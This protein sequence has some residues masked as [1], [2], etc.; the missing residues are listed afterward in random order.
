MGPPVSIG[1]NIP[2]GPSVIIEDIHNMGPWSAGPYNTEF[3]TEGA[4]AIAPVLHLSAPQ[5]SW[6][7]PRMKFLIADPSGWLL[8][9]VAR[10]RHQMEMVGSASLVDVAP[11]I[12]LC[13]HS[14]PVC[15]LQY[16]PKG[17]F[18]LVK[19]M[20]SSCV[21][22][23]NDQGSLFTKNHL[24]RECLHWVGVIGTVFEGH[25]QQCAR[26]GRSSS[27]VCSDDNAV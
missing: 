8:G 12:R 17:A 24:L 19:N 26:L 27:L 1:N 16:L 20:N 25:P 10:L 23:S 11:K 15:M 7:T 21:T 22:A 6:S 14:P 4:L 18:I 9:N 2:P 13:L 3:V 5:S